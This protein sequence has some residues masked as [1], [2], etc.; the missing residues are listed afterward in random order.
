MCSRMI[1]W[2][3]T[4]SGTNEDIGEITSYSCISYPGL[5]W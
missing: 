1:F 5:E 4:D 3:S 2:V